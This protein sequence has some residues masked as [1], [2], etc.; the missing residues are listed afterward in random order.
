MGIRNIVTTLERQARTIFI[1]MLDTGL[2]IGELVNLKMEDIHMDEGYLKV[3]GKT[4]HELF[5]PY[6][7]HLK[8]RLTP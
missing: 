6:Y 3:L 4:N 8:V 2:R 7:D 5:P 1:I